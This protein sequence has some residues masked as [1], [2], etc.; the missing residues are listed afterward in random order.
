MT[1]FSQRVIGIV[2][3]VPRGRVV[4]Y[5]QVAAY[6]GVPR[7]ARQV[8]WTLRQ[9]GEGDI[10]WWRVVNHL[11]RIT[12]KGNLYYDADAQRDLLLK[13][14]VT[15]VADFSL[16]MAKYRFVASQTQMK[17]WGLPPDYLRLVWEK[18]K[19]GY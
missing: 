10:P 7:A 12:I 13:E 16:E 2:R 19:V 3:Q 8:G 14:G 17:S 4:S 15:V 9:L 6:T 18:F 1:K 5:G 11:G